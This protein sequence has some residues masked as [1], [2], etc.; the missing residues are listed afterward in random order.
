LGQYYQLGILLYKR[1][2]GFEKLYRWK[3]R[4]INCTYDFNIIF[5]IHK[6]MLFIEMGSPEN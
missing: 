3:S 4:L 1:G 6:D 2:I 5:E